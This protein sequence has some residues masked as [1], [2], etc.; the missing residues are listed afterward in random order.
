MLKADLQAA[1]AASLSSP[2]MEQ[3][4]A[5]SGALLFY[6][7]GLGIARGRV[8]PGDFVVVV[9]GLGFLFASAR[10]LTNIN[11]E[12]Q[13]ALAA[14]QRV[15][16]IMDETPSIRDRPQA[17]S[18][19]GFQDE[20]RFESVVFHYGGEDILKGLST[21]IRR[22]ERVALVGPSGAGKTTLANLLPRFYDPAAGRIT[23]DGH[24]LRDLTLASLRSAIGVVTQETLLFDGSVRENIAFGN[25]KI[26]DEKLLAAARAAR[27]DEFIAGHPDGYDARVGESGGRF[28]MGQR[29]RLAIARALLKDPPI[30]ILDEATSSLD[31]ESE[32]LVQEALETLLQGRTSLIIAH[33]LATIQSADRILVLEAGRIVEEGRHA[34]L[35]AAGGLYA[36]LHALQFRN[37]AAPKTSSPPSA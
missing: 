4:G 3:I 14:A 8:D 1:R 7:A 24:D 16:A 20:I 2:I 10:R 5:M 35:L 11:V 28:S 36:R 21:T 33:R 29:Q 19:D 9:A 17:G 27:V 13:Q 15:F 12:V 23:I 34:D 22:G 32:H 25:E 18:L 30:L 37:G 31:A 6:L 26:S